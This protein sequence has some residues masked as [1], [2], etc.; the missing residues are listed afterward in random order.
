MRLLQPIIHGFSEK[1]PKS[2]NLKAQASQADAG[3]SP[4][5][6]FALQVLV[7]IR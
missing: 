2:E 6:T 3:K 5:E 4:Q 1:A 7:L